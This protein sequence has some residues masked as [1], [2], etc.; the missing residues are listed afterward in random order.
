MF[1]D[2]QVYF[3]FITPKRLDG[4]ITTNIQGVYFLPYVGTIIPTLVVIHKCV[5]LRV[6]DLLRCVKEQLVKVGLK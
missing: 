3:Y 1:S 2:K 5:L 4:N 6:K